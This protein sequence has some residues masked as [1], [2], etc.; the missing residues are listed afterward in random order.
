MKRILFTLATTILSSTALTQNIMGNW[1]GIL[2]VQGSII[3]LV[4]HISADS[5]GK[6]SA[7]FDSPRQQ[8]FNLP[9]NE[10]ILRGD[11]LELQMNKIKG[12]YIGKLD[13]TK[14]N[15]SG[16]WYQGQG[17][18][19]LNMK[20]VS[21]VVTIQEQ[22]RPQTPKPPFPY[23]SEDVE[24]DNLD[25]TIHFGGTFTVPLPKA[26]VDLQK[27]GVYPTVLMIT[28]SGKQDR[29]ETIFGHKPFAVIA[30]YLTR[31]GIAVLRVDD[32]DMGKTT[33][34]FNTATTA[35]FAKDVEAGLDYL[36]TRKE[37]DIHN[38]GLMGHSE[39]GM[40]APMV[41]LVRPEVKFIVLLAGPGVKI[42]DLMEQQNID[43]A[44]TQGVSKEELEQFRPLYRKMIS[45]I[46]AEK[47]STKAKE[48]AVTVIKKWEKNKT[49][50]LVKN[51]T[52]IS[53]EKSLEAFA[54]SFVKELNQPWF[55]YFIQFDPAFY[56][57]RIKCAV[58][59]L[60]GEK[61]IQVSAKSNLAGIQFALEKGKNR[62]F[63][64]I[65]ISGANHL[66]QHCKK[67]SVDE[68]GELEETFAP[69]VL[70]MIGT[71]INK[72]VH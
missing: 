40:I 16:I 42:K 45:T 47:D 48:K 5:T 13:G 7:T 61:D 6:F 3:S 57:T 21:G 30:D 34:N 63:K 31:H 54:R 9:F 70:E 67:C 65:E 46:L 36:K 33:G 10:V 43:V 11:S 66:F 35:D 64:T 52:G 4:F 24:Y 15:L 26:G 69:E 38:L 41:A 32:R 59:A 25:K 14:K 51:T 17:S 71:W 27:A 60:N 50:S 23:L 20:K 62:N 49:P 28:G 68:Y 37:V 8:A 12:K 39:G 44:A 18:L 22:K 56:L 1:E 53:D 58:L 72:T 2:T 19:P 29:D 55:N